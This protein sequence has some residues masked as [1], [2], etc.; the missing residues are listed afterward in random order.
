MGSVLPSH[1][2]RPILWLLNHVCGRKTRFLIDSRAV[3]LH[4]LACAA[5]VT[6]VRA[7]TDTLPAPLL[8]G[9][10]D[11]VEMH[12]L[13]REVWFEWRPVPR[14]ESYTI[15]I[16]CEHCCLQGR[17]CSEVAP[18]RTFRAADL[19][20]T[21]YRFEW[22]GDQ[23]GR[24]R[25]WASAGFIEGEKSA[26]RMLSFQTGGSPA[27]PQPPK[28]V[29]PVNN[30]V[31]PADQAEVTFEWTPV[32]GARSYTL[33]VDPQ[34]TCVLYKYCSD[35]GVY[36]IVENIADTHYTGSFPSRMWTRWRVW[37]VAG[38]RTSL[39]SPWTMFQHLPGAAGQL[40][41][42]GPGNGPAG[43]SPRSI[44]PAP[45]ALPAGTWPADTAPSAGLLTP[46]YS[47]AA[48]AAGLEGTATVYFEV[49]ASGET[50][51]VSVLQGLGMG[52]DEKA[53][54]LVG[55]WRFP[56]TAPPVQAAEISFRLNGPPGWRVRRAYYVLIQEGRNE[57]AGTKPV[58]TAYVRPDG[59]ACPV[60]EHSIV[61]VSF[62]VDR[63]GLPG[64]VVVNR[65]PAAAALRDAVLR[66]KFEPARVNGRERVAKATF[67]MECG[68]GVGAGPSTAFGPTK[69][70]SILFKT[71][72][73]YSEE[74]RQAKYNGSISIQVIVDQ[75]GFPTNLRVTHPIGLGLDQKAMEALKQW[76]FNPALRDGRPVPYQATVEISFRLL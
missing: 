21:R 37:A 39:K 23:R 8:T 19:Q 11:G 12:N 32:A 70:P 27:P 51:N 56:P 58:L 52:L 61:Q 17:F 7:Q 45:V 59:A 2:I 25:V 41:A 69:P 35:V 54:Q 74:A 40:S 55:S 75:D 16:D 63:S 53:V 3:R 71:D 6:I 49:A 65:S 60:G 43:P 67:E 22:F 20:G 15:E 13:P 30:A 66:W 18:S 46:E 57:P 64:R 38:D 62:E 47:D 24:W 48:R 14:A 9:P 76:R 1:S 50:R 10:A 73:A 26:W 34:S 68:A 72:P 29:A 4:I 5:L 33:E 44:G 28:V 42:A 36:R 31:L